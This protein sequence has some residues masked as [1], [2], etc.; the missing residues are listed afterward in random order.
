MALVE[1]GFVPAGSRTATASTAGFSDGSAQ[2]DSEFEVAPGTEVP[3]DPL[4][5]DLPTPERDARGSSQRDARGSIRD[6]DVPTKKELLLRQIPYVVTAAFARDTVHAALEAQGVIATL[7]RLESMSNRAKSSALLPEVRFRAG[8]D[9]DQSLRL[10]P[11]IEEPYRYSQSG[12]VSLILEGAV[13]W[14]LGRLIFAGEELG[15]ERLRL[16]Q[17]RER[18]RIT[19]LTLSELMAWQTAWRRVQAL[20][21]GAAAASEDLVDASVRLDALTAGWFSAHQPKGFASSTPQ[22]TSDRDPEPLRVPK[23]GATLV[24]EEPPGVV[25]PHG[26]RVEAHVDGHFGAHPLEQAAVSR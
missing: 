16:A 19:L 23:R 24:H 12:G 9:T 25:Q 3:L 18:Q 26:V 10:M 7:E 1:L 2:V 11:T 14:R 5:R 13:S 21:E 4:E 8:R 6:R 22:P 15:I 17:A 20:G